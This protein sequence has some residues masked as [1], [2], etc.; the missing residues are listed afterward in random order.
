MHKPKR[1]KN[2][3]RQPRQ[4]T[5]EQLQELSK[6]L[7]HLVYRH[8]AIEDYHAEQKPLDEDAM[9]TI[10]KDVNNRIYTLLKLYTSDNEKDVTLA[11]NLIKFNTLFGK[12]WDKAEFIP[13]TS[14]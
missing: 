12:N 11:E 1:N 8:S 7:T 6:A 2:N 4:L 13:F 5:E 3:T 9:K 10:N 14:I